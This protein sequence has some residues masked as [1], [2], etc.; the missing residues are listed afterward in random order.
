[1]E[2][3]PEHHSSLVTDMCM[4]YAERLLISQSLTRVIHGIEFTRS[5][6]FMGQTIGEDSEHK[7][8]PVYYLLKDNL[9]Q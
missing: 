3:D 8:P 9:I 6:N 5:F 7:L 2:L 4:G 1:M